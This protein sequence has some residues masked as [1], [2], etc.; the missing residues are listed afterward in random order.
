MK[1][2]YSILKSS[3]GI[4]V[5][6][7]IVEIIDPSLQD[8]DIQISHEVYLRISPDVKTPQSYINYLSAGLRY[9][10]PQIISKI[11]NRTVCFDVKSLDF[12]NA[13]FQEEALYCAIQG[14][15]GKYYGISI[16]EVDVYYDEQKNKYVYNV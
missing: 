10:T 7:D 15:V 2:K 3:W 12:A 13:D 5:I 9:L 8:N 16:P 6:I 4:V 14:W 11:G 1:Y